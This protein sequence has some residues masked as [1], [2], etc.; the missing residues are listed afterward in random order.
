MS[1]LVEKIATNRAKL[2][3]CLTAKEYDGTVLKYLC[4]LVKNYRG[5]NNREINKAIRYMQM[6]IIRVLNGDRQTAWVH[7]W[8]NNPKT[9]LPF[10]NNDDIGFLLAFK[11]IAELMER[12]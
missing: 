3:E 8:D 4:T 7:D 11:D 2:E 5:T 9:Y 10:N 12:L 6:Y 1:K